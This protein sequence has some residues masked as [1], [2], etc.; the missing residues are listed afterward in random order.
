MELRAQEDIRMSVP[1]GAKDV[2]GKAAVACARFDQ[3][4]HVDRGL[5]AS[6]PICRERRK[7]LRHLGDLDLEEVAEYRADVDAGKKI[8]RAAG[9]LRRAGVIAELGVIKRQIH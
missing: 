9:P 3:V 8:A 7:Q 1:G 6:F 2:G 5:R 4:E